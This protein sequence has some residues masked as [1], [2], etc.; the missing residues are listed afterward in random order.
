MRELASRLTQSTRLPLPSSPDNASVESAEFRII[1]ELAHS[2]KTPL[3]HLDATIG[4]LQHGEEFPGDEAM[5]I[6]EELSTSVELCKATLAAFRELTRVS[7]RAESWAPQSL[8]HSIEKA[9]RVYNSQAKKATTLQLHSPDEITGYSN[10][11]I[12][13]LILPLLENAVEAAPPNGAVAITVSTDAGVT[14]IVE[15][16][17]V[18]PVDQHAVETFG[19]ST[20]LNHEGI[21]V[22]VVQSLVGARAGGSTSFV[23]RDHTFSFTVTLP[24]RKRGD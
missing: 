16:E 11:Y 17:T 4:L 18:S 8:A 13:A 5:E 14:I 1:G 19:E 2:L 6:L 12:L 22:Q 21:G 20:K 9:H 24:G 15:N 10:N 7:G 23:T 3:A